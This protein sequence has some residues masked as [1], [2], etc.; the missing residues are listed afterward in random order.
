MYIPVKF[1]DTI[2]KDELDIEPTTFKTLKL[3]ERDVEEFLRRNINIIFEDEETLIV[4]GQQVRTAARGISDLTAIDSEG[5][6]VLIE[7]KRDASDI[8]GRAEAFEFQAIRYAASYAK[9]QTPEEVVELI[10]ST[11]IEKHKNEYDLGELTPTERARRDLDQ[12]LKNND[13]LRTFNG[14]QRILLVASSFD[15]QTLSAVA[16]LISNN[17]DISCFT[18]T[19]VII[20]EQSFLQIDKILPPA[21][22]DEFYVGLAHTSPIGQ[23]STGAS[24]VGTKKTFLPRMN[25]LFEWE[26]IRPGTKIKIRSH[27]DSEAEVVNEKT[28]NFKNHK[29]TYNQWGQ[30]VTGWSSINI[31]EWTLL[32]D[33]NKTLSELRAEKMDELEAEKMQT[34]LND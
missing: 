16:W 6:I 27:P 28:V 15:E 29:M 25:R 7:I 19:P 32:L 9:I 12:F 21:T 20:G 1:S 23:L 8:K 18:I 10:Y 3:K 2:E 11:Y 24:K 13:A 31:Y 5:S 17:V 14:K 30:K 22:L 34:A 33:K 26:L 4:V